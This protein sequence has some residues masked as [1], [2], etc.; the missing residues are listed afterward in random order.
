MKKLLSII[1]IAIALCF[2]SCEKFDDSDIWDKLDEYGESI[3]DHEN[4]ISALEELCS[5]MNT[6]ITAMQTII[7]AL[8]NRDYITNVSPIRKDGVEVGYTISFAYGDTI[9]IYHGKDGADG[10]NGENGYTPQ[11]GVMKDLDGIYYWTLDGEW[12]LDGK[13]NKIK[14]VGTDGKN[15]QDGQDG[16][17]GS[18]GTNG[19]DGKDGVNGT[20]GKDG[21]D[22]KDGQDGVTPR[23]KIENDYWYVSYDNGATWEKLCK[24]TS[25]SGSNGA[26]G[27]D[28]K[29]GEDGKDGITPR[30]KITNGY[31]YVSYDNGVTW[32]KLGKATGEDGQ[33]GTN[34]SNG[35]NGSNGQD[36]KDGVD[37]ITPRLKIENDYW[38]VSYDNGKSWTQL[39]KATGEDGEDGKDG[40]NGSDGIDG[41]DGLDGDSFFR[42]VTQDDENVYFTLADG[43]VITIQKSQKANN[44]RIYYTTS[45]NKTIELY[46]DAFDATIVSNT[47]KDGKGVIEFDRTITSIGQNAFIIGWYLT[48]ITLPDSITS[49]MDGAF[50]NCGE[51]NAFYSKFASADNRC[52]VIDGRLIAFAPAEV[53][54]YN[55]PSNVTVIGANIFNGCKNLTAISIPNTVTEIGSGAFAAAS[56]L[57]SVRVPDSIFVIGDNA[58]ASCV[59]LQSVIIGNNVTTIGEEAFAD[60]TSLTSITIPSSVISIEGGAFHSCQNLASVTIGSNVAEIGVQAFAYCPSLTSIYCKSTTPPAIYYTYYSNEPVFPL[61][62]G[63][64]IYVPYNSYNAYTQYE[65]YSEGN[66]AQ[67]N[68]YIYK[69]YIEPYYF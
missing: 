60:C 39:G 1:A 3:K 28:G 62:S 16:T 29:D 64:R 58:F 31:W 20:D 2:A 11:I 68:W 51:L 69:S 8:E 46:Q 50:C 26:N 37:G 61:N 55:I 65:T 17:N 13:G 59:N 53:T 23:L 67:T 5:Q 38:Y 52:L 25:E 35:A 41:E 15:G 9:T 47:Y 36:G 22:G 21:E 4:R 7:K 33:D 44:A 56:R 24:A 34:G 57:T 10:A 54:Q 12:L 19:T 6:N 42:S 45:D 27:Q 18:N 30:L 49:I 48:S 63:L 43:T 66:I 14:A 40:L 32:E